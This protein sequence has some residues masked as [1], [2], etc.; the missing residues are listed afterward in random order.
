MSKEIYQPE[1]IPYYVKDIKK[2]KLSPTEGLVYWFIRFYWKD[3]PFYFSSKDFAIIVW[4]TAGTIDNIILKLKQKGIIWTK[5]IRYNMQWQLISNRKVWAISPNNENEPSSPNDENCISP[6]DE[7]KRKEENNRKK[8]ETKSKDFELCFDE[9][10]KQY[11][12]KKDKAKCKKKYI[13]ILKK[14][15]DHKEIL[16]WLTKYKREKRIKDRM[17][18]FAPNFRNPQTW[19]NN[20]NWKD[21]YLEPT[22]NTWKKVFPNVYDDSEDKEKVRKAVWEDKFNKL[23]AMYLTWQI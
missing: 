14:W 17:W 9:F 16:S 13:A 22:F 12:I 15:E 8:E 3:K 4:T 23:I 10:W 1:F 7:I 5:T 21:D 2:Y 18:E 11:P 20:E 6:N 19:L